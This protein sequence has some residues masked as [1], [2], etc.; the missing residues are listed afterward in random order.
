MQP[1]ERTSVARVIDSGMAENPIHLAIHGPD[2]E[3][4]LRSLELGFGAILRATERPALVASEGEEILGAAFWGPPGSCPL[5]GERKE[6][7]AAEAK[8][9]PPA[10]RERFLA[11]RAA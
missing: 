5:S 10:V 9:R 6:P 7:L 2:R 8:A 3:A 1:E 4:R 11:W